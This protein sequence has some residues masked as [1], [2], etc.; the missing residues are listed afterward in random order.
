LKRRNKK[1]QGL[2]MFFTFLRCVTFNE[3]RT[4]EEEID[5]TLEKKRTKLSQGK[6]LV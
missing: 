2:E 3:K 1:D 6:C 4:K 5:K